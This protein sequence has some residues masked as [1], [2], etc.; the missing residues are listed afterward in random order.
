M[1]IIGWLLFGL[2]VG[3]IARLL[4]PGRDPM[5]WLGTIL[6]GILGSLAGAFL[7]RALFG[8]ENGVGWFGSIVGAVLLL[9][10]W[11]AVVERR[12]GAGRRVR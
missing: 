2:V 3:A 11:R 12:S 9:L 4:V 8:D 6:L 1:E 10:V 7:A 5:G